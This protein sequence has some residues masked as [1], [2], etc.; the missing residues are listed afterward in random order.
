MGSVQAL[1]GHTTAPQ[2]HSGGSGN[3]FAASPRPQA[4]PTNHVN[5]TQAATSPAQAGNPLIPLAEQSP[6]Q[7]AFIDEL[8]QKR[9]KT[10]QVTYDRVAQNPK[11]LTVARGEFLEVSLNLFL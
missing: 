8:L 4:P 5:G 6:R 7:R 1:N 11:E 3:G 9:A 2:Q 10:V